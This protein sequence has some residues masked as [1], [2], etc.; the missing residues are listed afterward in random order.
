MSRIKEEAVENVEANEEESIV[1]STDSA[2]DELE[3]ALS[4][5]ST[6]Y[7]KKMDATQLYLGEIGFSPLLTAEE[8]VFYSRRALKG[9]KAAR[10][11]M[12]ESNLRLVVKIARRYSNR[13]L[14]LLDLVEEGNL[15]LIRAV[16]K[17]DPE[18]GARFSTA[19]TWW[20]KS[21]VMNHVLENS[22]SFPLGK[23]ALSKFLFF[24]FGKIRKEICKDD[25]DMPV[26]QLIERMTDY[27]VEN[28][29]GNSSV[30][31]T[32]K[33]QITEFISA[34]LHHRSLDA[35]LN[36]ESANLTLGSM[37]EDERP[38]A[39]ETLAKAQELEMGRQFLMAAKEKFHDMGRGRD[40]DILE[41]RRLS[42]DKCT[43]QDL[44]DTYGV[45][46]ERIRQIEEKAFERLQKMVKTS[47]DQA[48]MPPPANANARLA[49]ATRAPS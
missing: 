8:E 10:R 48:T 31:K 33:R 26:P 37:L 21:Q 23:N 30:R 28:N 42:E 49:S 27:C 7:Q 3:E 17:F 46:R 24:N 20:I 6:Q 45:S 15:G 5:S 22:A 1:D 34:R 47:F 36:D 4:S 35:P 32:V 39:D 16:E 2:A 38:R 25:P 11:R 19:A 29:L 40:W 9:D 13:G 44:A 41:A 12:I 43:L 18:K 14:P